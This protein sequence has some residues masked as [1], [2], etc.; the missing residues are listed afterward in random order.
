M[1]EWLIISSCDGTG[2]DL[3]VPGHPRSM[4]LVAYQSKARMRLTISPSLWLWSYLAPFLR[5]D[6][7]LAKIAYFSY[8][9]LIR[10]PRFLCSLWNFAVRLSVGKLHCGS[11]QWKPHDRSWR[12]FD[13]IPDCDRQTD[14]R[15]DGRQTESIIANTALWIASCADAL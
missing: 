2:C 11:L 7:L 5:Y 14:R 12:Y 4:I 15:T 1:T 10:R 9:C 8:P 6:D 3:A 13:M